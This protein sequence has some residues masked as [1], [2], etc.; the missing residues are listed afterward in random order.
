MRHAPAAIIKPLGTAALTFVLAFSSVP[1]AGFAAEATGT[2]NTA[3]AASIDGENGA[4]ALDTTPWYSDIDTMIAKGG[5]AENEALVTIASTDEN[6]PV[7][8]ATLDAL[9]ASAEALYW[10]TGEVFENSNG[11]AVTKAALEAQAK[12]SGTSVTTSADVDVATVLVRSN[13]LSCKEILEGLKSN[14]LVLDAQPNY[15]LASNVGDELDAEGDDKITEEDGSGSDTSDGT[16]SYVAIPNDEVTASVSP[17]AAPTDATATTDLTSLQWAT[18]TN[19]TGYKSI[20]DALSTVN[21]PSWNDRNATN[22]TGVVAVMDTGVDYTHA[23]LAGSFFDMSPYVDTEVDGVAVGGGKYG[24]NA[25]TVDGTD[26]TEPMDDNGHGTHVA[27]IIAAATN[28]YGISGTANGAKLIAVKAANSSGNFTTASLLR[29]YRYLKRAAAAGVDLRA[30]NN[31]WTAG[32]SYMSDALY[33]AIYDLGQAGVVSIF[34]S[35]NNGID[36]DGKSYVTTKLLDNPYVVVVDSMDMDG[37]ASAFSNYGVTCTDV[38]AP[39]SSILSTTMSSGEGNYFPSL[40]SVNIVYT[41]FDGSLGDVCAFKKDNTTATNIGSYD[42]TSGFDATGGCMSFTGKELNASSASSGDGFDESDA[43]TRVVLKVPVSEEDLASVSEVGLSVCETGLSAFKAWIEVADSDG[44]WIYN[45]SE[46][47]TID[48]GNWSNLSLNLYSACAANGQKIGLFKDVRGNTYIKV[49]VSTNKYLKTTCTLKVDCIGLGNQNMDYA[50]M[51]GTSMATPLV[52]GLAAIVSTQVDA[53][54]ASK[55]VRGQKVANILRAAVTKSDAF[56]TCSSGGEVD[57][58]NYPAAIEADKSTP[59]IASSEFS[60]IEGSGDVQLTI[61]GSGFDSSA[62]QAMIEGLTSGD[63][64]IS[65]WTDDTVVLLLHDAGDYSAL[66][67]KV[68]TKDGGTTTCSISM[69]VDEDDDPDDKGDSGD[70][71]DTDGKGDSGNTDP[72]GSGTDGG[73][74]Q[75]GSGKT[76]DGAGKGN[77]GSDKNTGNKT[78]AT[79]ATS[80]K[81]QKKSGAALARTGDDSMLAIGGFAIAGALLVTAAVAILVIKKKR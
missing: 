70:K 15:D 42:A 51:S 8:Q 23:D 29:G 59:Y 28:G 61:V 68:E 26:P 30:V 3:A 32:A 58:S 4:D 14:E 24:Y 52:S 80:K 75:G 46:T 22:A 18:N 31:S 16:H 10:T 67:L 12:A 63:S 11:R 40:G 71:G 66:T 79:P 25:L 43:R 50:Y 78:D 76:D 7:D 13:T 44:G 60:K 64:E 53:S 39:G 21:V 38:Y 57:A 62:G 19:T 33:T 56:A 48:N 17:I 5:F 74:D 55:S 1:C 37:K 69:L 6:Q 35:G 54:G 34:A 9:D 20:Y 27:G 65:S 73:S 47:E 77:T 2:G 72:D 36:V 45:G 81:Q 41:S 49:A